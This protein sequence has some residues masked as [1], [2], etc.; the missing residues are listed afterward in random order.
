MMRSLA[1]LY[2]QQGRTDKSEQIKD[3]AN[4]VSEAVLATYKHGEG[5][6]YALHRDGQRVE[7]RHCY[8]FACIG[9]FM[10]EDLTG[11]MKEEMLAFVKNELL[12]ESWMRAMSLKDRAAAISDRPDHGPMGA[13]DSW[14]AITAGAMCRLGAWGSGVDFLRS[15]QAALDEG[16]Y[17]Q[18]REF[19]G[20][21]RARYTAPVRIAMRKGVRECTAAGP[22]RK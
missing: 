22:S 8:D 9:E 17:A 5:V 12:T 1:S 19:Y 2:R 15:T 7:L 20:P 14:P 21:D 11:K 16:V 18:A 3:L 13:F 10:T 6:W 4:Q